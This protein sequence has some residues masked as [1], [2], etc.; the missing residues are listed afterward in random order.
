MCNL[1]TH[2]NVQSHLH[3]HLTFI[4]T[5]WAYAADDEFT[6]FKKNLLFFLF[7]PENELHFMQVVCNGDNLHE[8][9]NLVFWKKK[10]RFL[11]YIQV[12]C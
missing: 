5:L 10:I 1:A 9:S 8:M 3:C 6:I 12:T 4:T 7:F 11:R 2:D